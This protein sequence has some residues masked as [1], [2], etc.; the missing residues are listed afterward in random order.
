MSLGTFETSSSSVLSFNVPVNTVCERL[1]TN[2][3]FASNVSGKLVCSFSNSDCSVIVNFV[4][5][6]F[7]L[8][9]KLLS[10]KQDTA[11]TYFIAGDPVNPHRLPKRKVI[12]PPEKLV[13]LVTPR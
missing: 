8:T 11:E 10:P 9:V 3:I 5:A 2:A 6:G 12:E 1:L 7:G 13:A 4:L